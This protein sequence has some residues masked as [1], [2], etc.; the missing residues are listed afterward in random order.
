MIY[1][2]Q[3]LLVPPPP[4]G[5]R[6]ARVPAAAQV[7]PVWDIDPLPERPVQARSHRRV[8]RLRRP[9]R[10]TRS[11]CATPASGRSRT[12]RRCSSAAASSTTATAQVSLPTDVRRRQWRVLLR[13]LRRPVAAPEVPRLRPAARSRRPGG[14]PAERRGHPRAAPV[15]LRVRAAA[16]PAGPP[17]VRWSQNVAPD[18][19]D[20]HVGPA[21]PFSAS[22]GF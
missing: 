4:S 1:S 8:S 3:F 17:V 9:P 5:A 19:V 15:A 20:P 13:G 22:M 6:A 7:S 11:R 12:G 14:H 18:V 2:D 21:P 16:R 10:R